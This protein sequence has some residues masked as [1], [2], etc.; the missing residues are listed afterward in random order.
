MN[1]YEISA[2]YQAILSNLIDD[3]TGEI[4]VEQGKLL[5]VI[6]DD[7][8]NKAIAVASYIK[9]L[10]AERYAIEQAKNAMRDREFALECKIEWL[11]DYLQV[12]M[13][14][15][16]INEIKCPYF[17]IKLKKCPVSTDIRDESLIPD[18]YKKRKEVVNVDKVKIKE[19]LQAGIN[20]PGAALKT[21][22]RLE[23]K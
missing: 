13:E 4:N 1:L 15:L 3:E 18:E 7:V 23:I 12:N 6:K 19:D 20:V 11:N 21:N 14:R 2:K 9:N 5:E 17:A 10:D 16:G 8:N 22:M